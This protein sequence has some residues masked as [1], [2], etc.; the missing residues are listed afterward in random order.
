MANYLARVELHNANYQDYETLHA[1]MQQRGY[2]RTIVGSN[3]A[4]YQLPTGT[5]V[6][7]D[8][9]ASPQKAFDAAQAAAQATG[10]NSWTIVAD[11]TTARFNLAAA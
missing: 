7:T 6:V 10:K 8:T 1:Q 4:T 3:G 2:V 5:Y 11:W 9:N